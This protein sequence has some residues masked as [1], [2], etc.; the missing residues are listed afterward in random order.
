MTKS[1]DSTQTCALNWELCPHTQVNCSYFSAERKSS[2]KKQESKQQLSGN[3]KKGES[4]SSFFER[5]KLY[6]WSRIS[7]VS[8]VIG[9]KG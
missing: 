2:R 3:P 4:L 5:R 6:T 1:F 9:V 8:G 7:F